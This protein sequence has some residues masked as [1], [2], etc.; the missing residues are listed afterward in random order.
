MLIGRTSAIEIT[1]LR[2]TF[3]IEKLVSGLMNRARFT[4]YNLKQDSRD[5]IKEEFDSIIFYAG[6]GGDNK[7]LFKGEVLNVSHMKIGPDWITEI[8]AGD[9]ATALQKA[10]INESF[11]AGTQTESVFNK[12]LSAMPGITKGTIDGA[13]ECFKK[14]RSILKTALLS[15]SVKQ[16]LDELS[17][18]CGFDYSINDEVLDVVSKDKVLEDVLPYKISQRNGMIGSPEASIGRVKV[19]T[20]LRPEIKPGR[21]I[22]IEAISVK[23]NLGNGITGRVQPSI[24]GKFKVIKLNHVGDTHGDWITEI[25]GVRLGAN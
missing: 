6:Y 23:L 13:T 1:D 21:Y 4:V 25:E 19:S 11:E 8:Y 5:R 17:R 15:G 9:G 12:L 18:N 3:E 7:L 20:L 24:V 14:N 16:F 10:T 2:V 22:E